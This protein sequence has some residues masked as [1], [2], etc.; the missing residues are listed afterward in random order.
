M[1]ERCG[2]TPREQEV[3]LLLCQ[4]RNRNVVAEMLGLSLNIAKVHVGRIYTKPCVNSHQELL[5]VLY[6]GKPETH[7]ERADSRPYGTSEP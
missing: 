5:D 7:S 3:F 1:A 2:L 6:G 4:G